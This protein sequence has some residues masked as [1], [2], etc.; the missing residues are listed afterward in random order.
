MKE[1]NLIC[2]VSNYVYLKILRYEDCDICNDNIRQLLTQLKEQIEKSIGTAK[3]CTQKL[4]EYKYPESV[5][6]PH[7]WDTFYKEGIDYIEEI[8]NTKETILDIDH[9]SNFI[10]PNHQWSKYK[11][12]NH[13]ERAYNISLE[14]IKL[15]EDDIDKKIKYINI[16]KGIERAYYMSYRISNKL[17]EYMNKQPNNVDTKEINK[18]LKSLSHYENNF[19]KLNMER[20]NRKDKYNI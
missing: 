12:V 5:D 13:W 10:R 20:H 6:H 7:I 4:L 3:Y 8:R 11:L 9:I 2:A 16:H 15:E 18:R 14:I 1:R 17:K 19:K